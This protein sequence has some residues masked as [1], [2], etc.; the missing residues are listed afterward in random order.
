MRK[1]TSGILMLA[2]APG[3]SSPPHRAAPE[4]RASSLT[5]Q[6][7]LPPVKE[8]QSAGRR[9]WAHPPL[10]PACVSSLPAFPSSQE[11]GAV[12]CCSWALSTPCQERKGGGRVGNPQDGPLSAPSPGWVSRVYPNRK[13]SASASLVR[14]TERHRGHPSSTP[15]SIIPVLAGTLMSESSWSRVITRDSP[16]LGR[17]IKTIE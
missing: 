1:P 3:H 13:S 17:G 10:H 14:T 5:R 4:P 6:K 11:S 12:V 15:A 8:T 7:H 16:G 9:A 2:L